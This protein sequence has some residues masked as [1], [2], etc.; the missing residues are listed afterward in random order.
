MGVTWPLKSYVASGY[1]IVTA[2]VLNVSDTQEMLLE[3]VVNGYVSEVINR[4]VYKCNSLAK[5]ETYDKQELI[6]ATME[7]MDHHGQTFRVRNRFVLPWS[8]NRPLNISCNASRKDSGPESWPRLCFWGRT[9]APPG[10]SV[11]LELLPPPHIPTFFVVL[12]ASLF[13]ACVIGV[14][15]RNR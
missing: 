12:P 2:W 3:Q 10:L 14:P 1:T 15:L 4:F 7:H 11:Y 13:I 6:W 9:R 8:F 5:M